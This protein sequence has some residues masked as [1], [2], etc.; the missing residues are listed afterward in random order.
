MINKILISF[1]LCFFVLNIGVS[2]A[3]LKTKAVMFLGTKALVKAAT[4][5]SMQLK[6]IKTIQKHPQF[7][8]K[9]VSKLEGI[10]ANP[11]HVNIKQKSQDFL[12]KVEN[13]KVKP[14]ATGPPNNNINILTINGKKPPN[15]KYAGKTHPEGVPFTKHGYPDF[16]S[17]MLKEV[18]INY[19]G[20]RSADFKLADQAARIKPGNRPKGYTWHHHEDGLR[21]QLVPTKVHD[22]VGHWG[23][24]KTGGVFD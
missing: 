13:I 18:R 21:M 3:G 22:S 20:S 5:P 11:K 1:V 10:I 12:A 14:S 17:F 16:S 6:M 8:N 19:T 7:K 2:Q 9:V 4:N 24:V 15:S 23:G